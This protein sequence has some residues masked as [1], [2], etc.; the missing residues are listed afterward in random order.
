MTPPSPAAQVR[1]IYR[2]VSGFGT[3]GASPRGLR[4][5]PGR[6]FV[7]GELTAVGVAQLIRAA[8]IGP[9]DRFVDLG[10]GVGK[11]VLQVALAVDGAMAMG[12]EIDGD[13]HAYAATALA[14]AEA[15]GLLAPGRCTFLHA[16][17]LTADLSA[18]TVFFA[19]SICF[20]PILL[21]AMARRIA[22]LP[23][24]RVFATLS[25]LPPRLS[26]AFAM[27]EQRTCQTSWS[28][29]VRLHVYRT[30]A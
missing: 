4:L 5:R 14:R 12:F 6:A 13:R 27:H 15:E 1:R 19:N 29:G 9:G 21:N 10:S 3:Q 23:G 30:A 11:I 26:A 18:G 2:G 7:Y 17:L 16:D 25:G 20:P 24:R 8:G 28:P 22:A